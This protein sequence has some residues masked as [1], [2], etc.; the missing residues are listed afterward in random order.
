M[1]KF[2]RIEMEGFVGFQKPLKSA[3]VSC[4]ININKH[5]NDG[6]T[7]TLKT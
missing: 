7:I 3:P 4:T 2:K 5:R 6:S 1:E